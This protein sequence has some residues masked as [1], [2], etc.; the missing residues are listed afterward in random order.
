MDVH[1]PA[2]ARVV[3]V[4]VQLGEQITEGQILFSLS[5]DQI[6]NQLER[7]QREIDLTKAM[8]NRIAADDHDLEQNIVLK[9]ELESHQE[10]YTGLQ[11]QR[12]QLTVRAPFSGSVSNLARN[13]HIDRWVAEGEHLIT[14]NSTAGAKVR[15]FV[16]RSNLGRINN[17]TEVVFVPE[18]PELAKLKGHVEL[19]EA[20]NAEV[21]NISALASYYGGRIAVNKN[22]DQFKPLKSWYQ[23]SIQADE[24]NQ[25]I[26]QQRRGTVLAKGDPE[27]FAKRL[28]RRMFH[29]AL[30][31]VFI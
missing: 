22:E 31:E 26:E 5:S 17:G 30:R 19:V 15:G 4:D 6:D 13:I 3:D 21:L 25:P 9:S 2:T 1:S 29:V 16:E 7:V 20:A 10:E 14:I 28:W 27:S 24:Y 12:E 23:V 8:L 11:T 18:V